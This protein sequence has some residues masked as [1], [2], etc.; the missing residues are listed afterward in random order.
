MSDENDLTDD[1]VMGMWDDGSPAELAHTDT[2]ESIWLLKN[3]NTVL[4][5]GAITR[6]TVNYGWVTQAAPTRVSA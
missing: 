6:R 1:E 5:E 4:S 2:A 3:T